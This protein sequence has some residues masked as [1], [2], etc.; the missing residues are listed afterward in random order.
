MRAIADD[1]NRTKMLRSYTAHLRV[2]LRLDAE[3]RGP[4]GPVRRPRGCS[5]QGRGGRRWGFAPVPGLGM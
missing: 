4:E 5:R 2:R 1:D 3:M